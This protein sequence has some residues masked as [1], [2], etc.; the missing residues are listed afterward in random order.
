MHYPK[1]HKK[2]A[3]YNVILSKQYIHIVDVNTH[4]MRGQCKV[5]RTNITLRIFIV[6]VVF[7]DYF[8]SVIYNHFKLYV[9]SRIII[10]KIQLY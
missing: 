10:E 2:Q 3:I 1:I 9:M 4:C 8:F 5:T 6:R 7:L